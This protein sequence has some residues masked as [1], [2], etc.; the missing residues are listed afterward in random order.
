MWSIPADAKVAPIVTA[1]PFI[2]SKQRLGFK[3]PVRGRS[4][5]GR[6][7]TGTEGFVSTATW[8]NN[9]LPGAGTNGDPGGGVLRRKIQSV[10]AARRFP[11]YVALCW[12]A[13]ALLHAAVQHID[14][15]QKPLRLRKP[16]WHDPA[17]FRMVESSCLRAF[18]PSGVRS[19]SVATTSNPNNR[20]PEQGRGCAEVF[21]IARP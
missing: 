9:L 12:D 10:A 21:V 13:L 8:R 4:P 17:T 2:Y 11:S 16:L 19:Q 14:L 6:E 5:G 1:T 18:G 3:R 20:E 7:P 15:N